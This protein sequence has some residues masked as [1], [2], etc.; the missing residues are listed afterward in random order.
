MFEQC[1]QAN[2]A[3]LEGREVLEVELCWRNSVWWGVLGPHF[4]FTLLLDWRCNVTSY[5]MFL[6][7]GN[8]VCDLKTWDKISSSFSL[9]LLLIIWLIRTTREIINNPSPPM[10]VSKTNV[11]S[12]SV[13]LAV[14]PA[15]GYWWGSLSSYPFPSSF[16]RLTQLEFMKKEELTAWT[17]W[18]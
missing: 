16:W 6:P 9:K 8:G 5:Y 11:V 3:P 12:L 1:P 13:L 14:F 15:S 10:W 7:Y 4:L 18:R 2:G 17:K